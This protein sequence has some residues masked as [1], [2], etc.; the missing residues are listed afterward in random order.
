MSGVTGPWTIPEFESTYF[1]SHGTHHVELANGRPVAL[2]SQP[3]WLGWINA[4]R[5]LPELKPCTIVLSPETIT[6]PYHPENVRKHTS[7]VLERTRELQAVSAD[8][9]NVTF[10]LGT[11]SFSEFYE[12]PFNSLVKFIDGR[13]RKEIRK[14]SLGLFEEGHYTQA[15]PGERFDVEDGVDAV[16]CSDV[17]GL[18]GKHLTNGARALLV[19]AC[20]ATPVDT[21]LAD[22]PERY[23]GAMD[24]MAGWVFRDCPGINE[25]LVCD[26]TTPAS[27]LAMPFNAHFHRTPIID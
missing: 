25:I 14:M 4:V 17:I 8:R 22:T 2:V 11:P 26:R 27:G 21:S 7:E 23:R 6:A 16:V 1:E 18:E 19:S 24:T 9:P 15:W 10:L 20:W 3:D 5:E 13:R 12:D